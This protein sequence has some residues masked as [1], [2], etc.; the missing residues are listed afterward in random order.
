MGQWAACTLIVSLTAGLL[1][2]KSLPGMVASR[3]VQNQQT[4]DLRLLP[5]AAGGGARM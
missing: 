2:M 3:N 5:L 4:A 1:L